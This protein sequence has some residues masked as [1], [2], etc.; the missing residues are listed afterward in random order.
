MTPTAPDRLVCKTLLHSCR[1]MYNY[2]TLIYSPPTIGD[3]GGQPEQVEGVHD[4]LIFAQ[5][6][7][8]APAKAGRQRQQTP[9]SPRRRSLPRRAAPASSQFSPF[10]G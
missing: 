10:F 9:R 2:Y 5:V 8:A 1:R 3:P 6:K 4:S 7:S